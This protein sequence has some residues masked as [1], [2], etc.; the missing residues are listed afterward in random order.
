MPI[1]TPAGAF[2]IIYVDNGRDKPA[3]T[4]QQLDYLTLVSIQVAALTEHIA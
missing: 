1:M 3:Y 4:Q 2:G